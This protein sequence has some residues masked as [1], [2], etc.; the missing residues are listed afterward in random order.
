MWI[1][2]IINRSIKFIVPSIFGIILCLK[3]TDKPSKWISDLVI[4][5]KVIG[6]QSFFQQEDKNIGS[7]NDLVKELENFER[8]FFRNRDK[9][10]KYSQKCDACRAIAYKLDAAFENAEA[11][12]GITNIYSFN[13]GKLK[14]KLNHHS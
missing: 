2:N 6:K 12:M 3:L 9:P 13:L 5:S 10:T 14:L 4:K 11:E 1:S 8:N 7:T